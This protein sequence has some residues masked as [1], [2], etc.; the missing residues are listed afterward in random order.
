MSRLKNFLKT[1]VMI[2]RHSWTRCLEI[3]AKCRAEF[4]FSSFTMLSIFTLRLYESKITH[5][6]HWSPAFYS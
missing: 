6:H 3:A 2:V 4:F 1:A 5:I